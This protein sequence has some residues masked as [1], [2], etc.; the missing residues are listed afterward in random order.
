MPPFLSLKDKEEGGALT[1]GGSTYIILLA[2]QNKSRHFYKTKTIVRMGK[3][4][5]RKQQRLEIEKKI[6]NDVGNMC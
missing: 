4:K 6:A 5:H 3:K 1:S 2:Q